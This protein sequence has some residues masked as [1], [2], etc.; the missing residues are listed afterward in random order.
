VLLDRI[1]VWER[2]RHGLVIGRVH[3][4]RHDPGVDDGNGDRATAVF[5][6][7]VVDAASDGDVEPAVRDPGELAAGSGL[8]PNGGGRSPTG[9]TSAGGSPRRLAADRLRT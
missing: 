8:A 6:A 3:V 7:D 1:R 5:D 9:R 4:D 2:E